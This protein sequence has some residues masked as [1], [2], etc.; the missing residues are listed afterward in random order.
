MF[1]V[2]EFGNAA[3]AAAFDQR[4]AAVGDVEQALRKT[5]TARSA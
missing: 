5:A 3:A 1:V 2:T 4:G